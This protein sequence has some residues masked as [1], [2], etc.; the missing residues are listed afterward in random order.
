[1]FNRIAVPVFASLVIGLG[2]AAA[3]Q[4]QLPAAA[5]GSSP[6]AA[7]QK[8]NACDARKLVG[9]WNGQRYSMEILADSTYRASGAPNM[10]AIDVT[11][12]LRTNQ[13]QAS[14]VDTSGRFACPSSNVGKYTFTVTDT[15]LAF[16]LVSDPCEGRRIPLTAGPLTRK[17]TSRA[18]R[19]PRRQRHWPSGG[20]HSST[21]FPSGSITQPNFP[22]SESSVFSRTLHPSWR[23]ISSSPARSATR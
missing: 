14:I 19:A 11:G 8:Q 21:L 16:T 23:R 10:A 18:A 17:T 1:M 3:G 7:A 2:T 13:C 20:C 12:T 9:V 5:S 15:R 22:Y 6:S 4:G